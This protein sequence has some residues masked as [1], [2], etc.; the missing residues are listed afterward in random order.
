[1]LVGHVGDGPVVINGEPP[2]G[3]AEV[4]VPAAQRLHAIRFGQALQGFHFPPRANQHGGKCAVGI[5]A[6]GSGPTQS[7]QQNTPTF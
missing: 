5:I 6:G 4:I 2:L 7:L 3:V 1:M